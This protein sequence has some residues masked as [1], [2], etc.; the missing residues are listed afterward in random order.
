VEGVVPSQPSV[1]HLELFTWKAPP[2][3]FDLTYEYFWGAHV[4]L[5]DS[6]SDDE[7]RKSDLPD[8]KSDWTHSTDEIDKEHLSAEQQDIN[9]NAQVQPESDEEI[10]P[11][12]TASSD[13]FIELPLAPDIELDL[14]DE[15]IL[16]LNHYY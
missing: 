4:A 14:E 12:A 2:S 6:D 13:N 9:A 15:P 5:L 8:D 7:W 16:E 3:R 1:E 10:R 11:Q